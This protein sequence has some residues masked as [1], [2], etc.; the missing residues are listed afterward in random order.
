MNPGGRALRRRLED[1]QAALRTS[2]A[3][4]EQQKP[5]AEAEQQ[6][7]AADLASVTAAQ[8]EAADELARAR[9]ELRWLRGLRRSRRWGGAVTEGSPPSGTS[10]E[11][12]RD[13]RAGVDRSGENE[14]SAPSSCSPPEDARVRLIAVSGAGEFAKWKAAVTEIAADLERGWGGM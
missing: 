1:L 8:E 7:L 14:E 4:L 10:Q 11:S 9:R 12:E 13:G 2:R 3:D 5:R 6:R